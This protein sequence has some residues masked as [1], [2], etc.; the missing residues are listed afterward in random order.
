MKTANAALAVLSGLSAFMAGIFLFTVPGDFLTDII[1]LVISVLLFIVFV[2]E[3][4]AP[5]PEIA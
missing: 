4:I 3:V 1:W 2:A 5:E